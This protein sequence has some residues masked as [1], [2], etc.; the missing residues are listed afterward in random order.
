M[1]SQT[2]GL[3]GELA[4]P[5]QDAAR[6][7]GLTGPAPKVYLFG[8]ERGGAAVGGRAAGGGDGAEADLG[9]PAPVQRAAGGGEEEAETGV[10]REQR[11]EAAATGD[12]LPPRPRLRHERHTGALPQHTAPGCPHSPVTTT[13]SFF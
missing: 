6:L 9:E 1:S 13:S 8:G 5:C 10:G 3:T 2:L 4:P 7:G 12:Q 11:A